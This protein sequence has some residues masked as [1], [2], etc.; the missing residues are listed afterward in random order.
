MSDRELIEWKVNL[1]DSEVKK[2]QKVKVCDLIE[3]HHNVFS[4]CDEI[5]TCPQAEVHLKV[6]NEALFLFTHM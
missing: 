6:Y 4:F 5:R 3:E 2:Q 1:R